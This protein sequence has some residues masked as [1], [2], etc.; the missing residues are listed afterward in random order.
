MNSGWLQGG[1]QDS[2]PGILSS[3]SH[4]AHWVSEEILNVVCGFLSLS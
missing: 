3:K 4:E 2:Y 1:E